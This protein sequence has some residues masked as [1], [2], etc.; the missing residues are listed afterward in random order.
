VPPIPARRMSCVPRDTVRI[1]GVTR[2]WFFLERGGT[3]NAA[4]KTVAIFPPQCSA[5]CTVIF[6][7]FKIMLVVKMLPFEPI[8]RAEKL[9]MSGVC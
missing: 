4:G 7:S 8:D 3:R 6:S 5:V 9:W 2:V 1:R